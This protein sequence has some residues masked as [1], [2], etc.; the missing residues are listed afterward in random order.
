MSLLGAESWKLLAIDPGS[1][2]SAFVLWDGARVVE[3]GYLKNREL[4]ERIKARTFGGPFLTVVEQIESFGMAVGASVFETVFWSG[5]FAEAS[6]AFARLPRKTIKL[7]LC[8]TLRAKDSNVRQ[9]L[10]DRFGG[11]EAAMGKKAAPGPLYG[12]TSHRWSALAVAVTYWDQ[13]RKD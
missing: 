1:E 9:A 3:H 5:R 11:R 6:S 4:L 12:V 13:H 7:H 8:Q 10:I 2:W